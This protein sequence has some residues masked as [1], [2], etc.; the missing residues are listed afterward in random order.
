MIIQRLTG[1]P[2][3]EELVAPMWSKKKMETMDL[4]KETLEKRDS[5]QGKL[6]TN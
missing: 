2:H 5:W 6:A 1:D 3:P 4:I